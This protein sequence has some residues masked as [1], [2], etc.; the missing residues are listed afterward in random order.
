VITAAAQEVVHAVSGTISS[1]DSSAK[2][3]QI[4]QD[5]GFLGT[6]K[7]ATTSHPDLDIDRKLLARLTP[8]DKFDT[9]G[10]HVLVFYYGNSSVPTA[11]GLESLGPG[12]FTTTSGAVT[13]FEKHQRCITITGGSGTAKDVTIVPTTVAETSVGVVEGYKFDPEKGEQIRVTSSSANGKDT[14]LYIYAK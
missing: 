8:A 11:V 3:I 1:I 7:D 13:K 6:F 9:K 10:A 2:T 12:P 5:D 4:N 14:A